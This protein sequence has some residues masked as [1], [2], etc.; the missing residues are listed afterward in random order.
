MT[1]CFHSGVSDVQV[2]F[3]YYLLHCRHLGSFIQQEF[4]DLYVPHFCGFDEW[5]LSILK[6]KDTHHLAFYSE[7]N[8][9]TLN[10]T[11]VR[12]IQ[13]PTH[14]LSKSKKA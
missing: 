7:Q 10:T 4:H 14:I 13:L 2:C 8:T 6:C 3:K 12:Q 9:F 11:Q 1:I 5:G